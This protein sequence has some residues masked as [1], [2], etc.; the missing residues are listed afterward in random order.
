VA[1]GA[2]GIMICDES[3]SPIA[4]LR[5]LLHFFAVESCGKCTPCR[6]GTQET[7]AI[8]DRLAAGRGRA[9][10]VAELHRLADVLLTGSFCGLGQ[11]A[12]LPL[13]T[14]LAAFPAV[15]AQAERSMG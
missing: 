10:D 4:L 2:G 5:E 3:V 15:F 11:S 8:L 1:L 6:A 7:W 9:G 13:R 12:A 14:A